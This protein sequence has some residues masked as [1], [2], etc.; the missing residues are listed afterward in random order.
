RIEATHVVDARREPSGGGIHQ[1]EQSG[2][3]V[4]H[5][6]ERD[7]R[8]LTHEGCVRAALRGR[9]DHF[10][11][12][13]ARAPTWRRE[14]GDQAWESDGAK[15]D[16]APLAD[17]KLAIVTREIAAEVLAIQLVAPVHGDRLE[18]LVLDD[19]TRLLLRL[20]IRQPVHG[21]RAGKE[22]P[23][24]AAVGPGRVD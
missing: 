7:A 16:A 18:I 6:H 20:E 1:R 23:Y 14:G 8:V 5:R 21:D 22:K 12:I 17:G 13:V 4:R 15:V 24:R 19:T 10:R 9:V 11:R 3:R 2:D